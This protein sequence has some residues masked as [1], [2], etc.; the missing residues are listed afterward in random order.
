VSTFRGSGQHDLLKV[1]FYYENQQPGLGE[2]FFN[3]MMREIEALPRFC[4]IHPK[5][6]RRHYRA[7]SARAFLFAIFY[8]HSRDE[9]VVV[10]VFDGRCDPALIHQ[11][12][13][14]DSE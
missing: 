7:L 6:S 14:E 8:R 5:G 4:G 9:L 12:L 1:L 2:R 11:R 13:V 10:A 3:E